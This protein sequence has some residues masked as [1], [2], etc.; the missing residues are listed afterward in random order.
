MNSPIPCLAVPLPQGAVDMLAAAGYLGALP[1]PPI[2]RVE[3]E[4]APLPPTTR[5]PRLEGR[6]EQIWRALA[7]KPLNERQAEIL[8]IYWTARNAGEGPLPIEEV[9]RRLAE[10]LPVDPEKAVDFVKGAL[11]SF[12][13]RLFQTLTSP[14]VRLG[15]DRQGEGVGDEIPLLAMIDIVRSADGVAFHRMTEDGMVAVAAALG[16]NRDGS[17][18]QAALSEDGTVLMA[19]SALSA[20]LILR[21][22]ETLGGSVDDAIQAMASRMG[23]G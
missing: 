7:D 11:R 1:V 10:S 18:R 12:G 16:L 19:M 23:A 4:E 2:P 21:V 9:A 22:Q 5:M 13:R 15:R 3:V 8:R 20:A 14:P 6:R 17:P